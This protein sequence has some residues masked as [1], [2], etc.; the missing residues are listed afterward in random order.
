MAMH[1]LKKG[2]GDLPAV[3]QISVAGDSRTSETLQKSRCAS[4]RGE[5][6]YLSMASQDAGYSSK[7]TMN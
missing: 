7:H 1:F 6:E 3:V 4:R 2:I 5:S